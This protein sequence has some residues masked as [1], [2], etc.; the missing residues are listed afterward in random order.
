MSF[1]PCNVKSWCRDVIYRHGCQITGSSCGKEEAMNLLG[2]LW[3][4]IV[5]PHSMQYVL[6]HSRAKKVRTCGHFLQYR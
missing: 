5:T 4:F 1:S 6:S 2:F 3:R